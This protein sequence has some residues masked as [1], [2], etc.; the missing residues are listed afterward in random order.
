MTPITLV[1]GVA[2][3]VEAGQLCISK[4]CRAWD[5]KFEVWNTR[6]GTIGRADRNDCLF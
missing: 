6:S 3:D 2:G 1:S 5:W 4:A